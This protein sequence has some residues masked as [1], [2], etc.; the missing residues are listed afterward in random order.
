MSPAKARRKKRESAEDRAARAKTV[1]RRLRKLYPDAHCELDYRSPFELAVATVLSA[2]CTDK[3]VNLVTPT[4]FAR[5]PSPAALA[6]APIE[7]VEDLIKSTGFFRN[8][9]RSITGLARALV[10]HYG[11]VLPSTMDDLVDLPGIGRKTAN[12]ILGNAYG[13]NEGVVVDTH[14]ARLAERLGLTRHNDAVKIER[15][16]MA[17]FERDTWTM[18]AH[19]LIWHGRRICDARKPKCDECALAGICPSA[20]PSR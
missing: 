4:L 2:Q 19:L 11:G 17:L 16:L 15:D 10:T 5:F 6:A 13:K 20:A 9:A 1:Y 18:L 12:V 3:R 7:A 8:K 14:I